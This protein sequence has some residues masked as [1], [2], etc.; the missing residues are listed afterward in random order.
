MMIITKRKNNNNNNDNS[1]NSK[2]NKNLQIFLLVL[3][4]QDELREGNHLFT[5]P[6]PP[7]G[8]LQHGSPVMP[9]TRDL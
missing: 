1:N 2:S 5:E 4:L 6:L 3:D 7:L 9:R 8:Q